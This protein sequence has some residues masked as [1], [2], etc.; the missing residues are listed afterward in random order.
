M[1]LY[2]VYETLSPEVEHDPAELDN[3]LP[4][5]VGIFNKKGLAKAIVKDLTKKN[6]GK[7]E[8]IIDDYE[9]NNIYFKTKEE[10]EQEI[11]DSIEEMVKNG[12]MDYKVGEDGKFYFELT[13]KGKKE[14]Q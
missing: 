12:F 14:I 11:S 8:Y 7:Y 3:A 6:K 5:I 2:V 9:L 4:F 1:K 10:V 13:E